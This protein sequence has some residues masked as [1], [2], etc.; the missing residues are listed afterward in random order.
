MLVMQS[1]K[2]SI[3]WSLGEMV[4]WYISMLTGDSSPAEKLCMIW[5]MREGFSWK[6]VFCLYYDW[7]KSEVFHVTVAASQETPVTTH[8]SVRVS[9]QSAQHNSNQ[10]IICWIAVAKLT[11]YEIFFW[12]FICYL[13][14]LLYDK[15]TQC[16]AARELLVKYLS[17]EISATACR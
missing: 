3:F 6:S 4:S 14:F 8:D 15:P 11:L 7:S 1:V 16:A 12:L 17:R 2:G 5:E 10:P 9:C 13:I